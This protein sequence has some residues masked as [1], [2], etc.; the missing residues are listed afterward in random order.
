VIRPPRQRSDA[1]LRS[2]DSFSTF[3]ADGF[4]VSGVVDG[5]SAAPAE[6]HEVDQFSP[7]IAESITQPSEATR[8]TFIIV[9]VL[10]KSRASTCVF[11]I[12][13]RVRNLIS[14]KWVFSR[15][16]GTLNIPRPLRRY[17]TRSDRNMA[18]MSATNPE[19]VDRRRSPLRSLSA[20]SWDGR[21]LVS[22]IMAFLS[23]GTRH[24]LRSPEYSAPR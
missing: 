7:V 17:S 22:S 10:H 11:G 2:A 14:R 18:C 24:L 9:F 4:S 21:L 6:S 12:Q 15:R 5:R 20:K 19:Q 3:W 13:I 1:L 8:G 23:V 16:A